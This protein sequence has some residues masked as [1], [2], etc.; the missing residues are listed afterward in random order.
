M[1]FEAQAVSTES[2]T[3]A[4]L[5]IRESL[6]KIDRKEQSKYK[7]HVS[8]PHWFCAIVSDAL[9]KPVCWT[10]VHQRVRGSPAPVRGSSISV[11]DRARAGLA[12]LNTTASRFM[13]VCEV[14]GLSARLI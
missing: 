10:K 12:R 2:A 6:V 14:R 11:P 9:E 5:G 8:S 13:N 4:T 7:R 1:L 3:L